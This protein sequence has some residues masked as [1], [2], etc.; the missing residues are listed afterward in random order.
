MVEDTSEHRKDLIPGYNQ[1][2]MLEEKDANSDRVKAYAALF[3]VLFE[4]SYHLNRLCFG[5]EDKVGAVNP[6]GLT[7]PPPLDTWTKEHADL[8]KSVVVILSASGK[9]AMSLAYALRF[10]RPEAE[11]PKSICAVGSDASRAFTEKTKLYDQML[12]YDLAKSDSSQVATKLG[13]SSTDKV[14]LFDFGARGDSFRVW[15]D[16]LRAIS[17]NVLSIRMAEAIPDMPS[18]IDEVNAG[19]VGLLDPSKDTYV[20]NAFDMRKAGIERLGTDEYMGDVR[21]GFDRFIQNECVEAVKPQWGKGLTGPDGVEGGWEK[22]N[23]GKVDPSVGL[24]YQLE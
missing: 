5:W 24:L 4:T 2:Y 9:T 18:T 22:I 3:C 12:N 13:I 21:K 23:S 1:Y 8:K 17:S 16:A 7:P 19:F 6:L 20:G 10:E 15:R 14:V 11:Q